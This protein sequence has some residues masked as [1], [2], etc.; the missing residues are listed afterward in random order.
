M[1]ENIE[2]K[3]QRIDMGLKKNKLVTKDN[4][5]AISFLEKEMEKTFYTT[6]LIKESE[7]KK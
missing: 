7:G 3:N 6:E 2:L 4:P 1:S 5:F